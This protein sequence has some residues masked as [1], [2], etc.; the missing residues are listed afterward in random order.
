VNLVV[1]IIYHEFTSSTRNHK[2]S[3]EICGPRVLSLPAG[4]GGEKKIT[5]KALVVFL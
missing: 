4:A 5:R 3:C 1:K 2:K